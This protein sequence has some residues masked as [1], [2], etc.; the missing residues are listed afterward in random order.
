ME[1]GIIGLPQS[2][3]TTVF[4]ALSSGSAEIGRTS[5]SITKPNLGVAKVRDSRLH[6]LTQLYHPRKTVPAEV[7]YIDLPQQ[8]DRFLQTKGISG[9][10][11]NLLQ[12]THALVHVVKSFD[13]PALHNSGANVD[14]YR[15]LTEMNLELSF[16]D[17]NMLERRLQRI[18]NDLKSVKA[19][20]RTAKLG[21]QAIIARIIEGLEKE[22][23]IRNQILTDREL[24][25]TDDFHLLTRKPQLVI[26]NIGH[27]SVAQSDELELRLQ[28]EHNDPGSSYAVLSGSLEAELSDMTEE[29]AEEFRNVMGLGT[30]GIDRAI[31]SSYKLLNLI[32]FF[33]VGEDEVKAWTIN[34]D[35]TAIKAAGKIHSDIERGFIR[36]EV[37]S[38]EHL[39]LSGSIVAARKVGQVRSEGKSYTVQDGDIINFLFN[40]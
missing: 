29:E 12:Q 39:V 26:W 40:V 4:N 30:P 11:L 23:P 35:T 1:I 21:E 37:I 6:F 8:P 31:A 27:D 28:S 16:S 15:D 18:N 7:T 34:K 33:T 22:I 9:E 19:S 2:G 25:L 5:L 36:A 17:L 38:Y 10:Y 3:K 14:P 32:S 13:D 24:A 20:A